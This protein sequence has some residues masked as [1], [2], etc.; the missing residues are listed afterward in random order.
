MVMAREINRKAVIQYLG[1]GDVRRYAGCVGRFSLA[2]T[3]GGG[4]NL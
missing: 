4:V 3:V 2:H 1:V